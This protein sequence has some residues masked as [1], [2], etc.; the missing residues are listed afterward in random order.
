MSKYSKEDK[1]RISSRIVASEDW[2]FIQDMID[3][4]IAAKE[5]ELTSYVCTGN[6]KM[7]FYHN[8]I[9]DGYKAIKNLPEILKKEHEN[10][11]KRVYDKVMYENSRGNVLPS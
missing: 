3:E 4:L 7:V 1:L 9:K 10:F 8:G 2:N 5:A 6:T 11:F